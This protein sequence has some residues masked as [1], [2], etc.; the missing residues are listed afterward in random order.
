MY[1]PGRSERKSYFYG[2]ESLARAG[3]VSVD[4]L[5]AVGG[6]YGNMQALVA[7]LQIA[8]EEP[9][10]PNI[11]FNGDFNWFN[12]D[13]A[14]FEQIND[15]VLDHDATLGNVEAEL[16]AL[17]CSIGCGCAYPQSV[18]TETVCRSNQIHAML[19]TTALRHPQIC[20]RLA[21][22]PMFRCYRVGSCRIGVVHGDSNSLAGWNF[23]VD[24]LADTNRN[25]QLKEQFHQAHVD[26]FASSHTCLPALRI[27]QGK[28]DTFCVI[29]N[30]AAGLPNFQ[31]PL[32]GLITRIGVAPSPHIPLYGTRIQEVFVDA[33]PVYYSQDRWKQD[34]LANWPQGSPAYTSYFS[35]ITKGT[36][37]DIK[38]S[39]IL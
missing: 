27:L 13:D 34:F 39:L 7:I 36:L 10:F 11:V 2:A 8:E 14:S 29:N 4:C 15:R 32:C 1:S 3:E 6:L 18:D 17:E 35:R 16:V 9:L 37:F 33:I 31:K 20:G 24:A 23:S 22:L 30:G 19:R 26:I 38:K 21:C 25:E 12:V 5:Y 28:N